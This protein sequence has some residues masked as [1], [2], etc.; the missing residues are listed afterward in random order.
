MVGNGFT[1]TVKDD[2]ELAH[3]LAFFTVRFPVYVPAAVLAGT[4]I[5]IALA[6]KEASV[7]VA[8]LFEGDAFHVML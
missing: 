6:G 8:K 7:T 3:P 1:V 4:V 5:V 2:D